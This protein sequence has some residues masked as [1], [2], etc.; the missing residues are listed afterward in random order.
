MKVCLLLIV[1][2]L[3]QPETGSHEFS[4]V[5]V[6][7]CQGYLKS[8]GMGRTAQVKRD[9]RIGEAEAR[10]D[11]TIRV[12]ISFISCW[13]SVVKITHQECLQAR[14]WFVAYFA[15]FVRL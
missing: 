8:L 4:H 15:I 6:S 13:K 9:A 7:W 11:A 1:D 14:V 10:R 3:A 5:T 12:K 2:L